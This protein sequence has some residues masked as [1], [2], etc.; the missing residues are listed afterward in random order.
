MSESYEQI[1]DRALT[2]LKNLM[3]SLQSN[4][5]AA[6]KGK[7]LAYWLDDYARLLRGEQQFDPKKLI[8]YKRGSIVKVH[9]GYNIGSEEGGLHYAVV[10]DNAETLSSPTLTVIPLT[11]VKPTTNL[12]N[13]H[14]SKLPLGDEIYQSLHANLA[15]EVSSAKIRL[16]KLAEH[17]NDLKA[18]DALDSSAQSAMQAEIASLRK[19][20]AYC[21]K[22]QNEVDKMKTGSIAL[23]GQITTISK[24]R[25]YD[26]R[27]HNDAL[28][29]VRVSDAT[30]DA[31]DR[32]VIELYTGQNKQATPK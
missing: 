15:S 11:S 2:N 16:N 5:A 1:R 26:P 30:L 12:S 8:R 25:I 19:A 29:K 24:I 27:Y 20:L 10:M 4:P 6:G 7:I 14:H 28:A 23:V 9:L 22:M 13:L 32:K 3:D 17:Y 21:Q 31:L 18:K